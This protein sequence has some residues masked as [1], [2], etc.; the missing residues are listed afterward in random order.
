MR[1]SVLCIVSI[2]LNIS[3][4]VDACQAGPEDTKG[5]HPA[6]PS[7]APLPSRLRDG[8]GALHPGRLVAGEGAV[9][10]VRPL[11]Q[12][13]GHPGLTSLADRLALHVHAVPLDGDV[14][15]ERRDVGHDD[16]DLSRLRL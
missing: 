3:I 8:E 2:G 14:V 15:W 5:R 6:G 1:G 16:G 7:R 13:D 11:L 10:L 4:S 9:E 12:R